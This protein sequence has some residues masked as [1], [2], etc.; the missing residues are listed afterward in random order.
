MSAGRGIIHSEMPQQEHGRMRGFQLWI[1][2]PAAEKM[3]A[4][5]YRDIQPHEIPAIALPNGGRV[6]VIAGTLE[7]EGK[8]HAGPIQGL[9]T[10]PTYLDV[11]LPAGARFTH[12]IPGDYNAFMYVYEG[13]VRI[14]ADGGTESLGTHSAGLLSR[15]DRVEIEAHGEGARLLLFAGRPLNEPIVQHGPFVMNTTEEIRQAI[16]DYQSGRLGR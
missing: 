1:N 4:P 2:L 7:V 3:K 10:D 8:R 14:G 16:N 11:Q 15:G 13:R 6:K 12:A 5:Q 9:S